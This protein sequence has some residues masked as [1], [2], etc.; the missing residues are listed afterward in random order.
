MVTVAG[1]TVTFSQREDTCGAREVTLE[2]TVFRDG[3][4]FI[5]PSA[6]LYS[7]TLLVANRGSTVIQGPIVVVLTG[8]PTH[9]PFPDDV[10]VLGASLT[11]CFS[12]EGDA[13]VVAS[14]AELPPGGVV[15]IPVIFYKQLGGGGNPIVHNPRVFVGVP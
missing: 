13:Y 7:S 14:A 6:Y 4:R 5:Y 8:L 1:R 2:T 10:G 11:T 3:P 9:R 15:A 12:P